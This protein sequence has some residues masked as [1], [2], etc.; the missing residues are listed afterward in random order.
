[1]RRA[2]LLQLL[3]DAALPLAIAP[4]TTDRA[5]AHTWLTGH[6]QAGIEGLSRNASATDTRLAGTPGGK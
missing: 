4:M 3:E 6:L 5:A 1:M 2:L